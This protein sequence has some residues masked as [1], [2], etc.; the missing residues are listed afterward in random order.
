MYSC[1][2]QDL[3]FT[4]SH[5]KTTAKLQKTH[6]DRACKRLFNKVK[7]RPDAIL[8]YAQCLC[9]ARKHKFLFSPNQKFKY[10]ISHLTYKKAR[11]LPNTDEY[12]FKIP[13]QLAKSFIP[14]HT[15]LPV[16]DDIIEGT[17]LTVLPYNPTP[18]MFIPHKYRNIIPPDPLYDQNDRFIIPG[19]RKWFTYIY[20]LE[21]QLAIQAVEVRQQE[22][23]RK[24]HEFIEEWDH[25]FLQKTLA[26]AAYHGTTL[27]YLKKQ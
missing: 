22:L 7:L 20:N 27:K 19:S 10:G 16:D 8:N 14:I 5:K 25:K 21:K 2:L 1:G 23:L 4:P 15:P 3:H 17:I 12:N 24:E 9:T 6:F 26:R 11:V 18:N 13:F